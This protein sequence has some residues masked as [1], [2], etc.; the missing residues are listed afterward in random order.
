MEL[1]LI[2]VCYNRFDRFGRGEDHVTGD[3]QASHYWEFTEEFD[4]EDDMYIGEES[5]E[6]QSSSTTQII[7]RHHNTS[8]FSSSSS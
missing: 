2:C 6:S 1:V 7:H 3:E 4:E 5:P 8:S